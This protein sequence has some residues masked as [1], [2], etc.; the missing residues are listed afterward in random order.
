VRQRSR[1]RDAL[2]LAAGQLARQTV[3]VA[4]ERDEPQ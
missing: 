1:Q 2:L 4:F 3:V